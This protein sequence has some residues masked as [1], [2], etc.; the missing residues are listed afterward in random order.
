[1]VMLAL[2]KGVN[3]VACKSRSKPFSFCRVRPEDSNGYFTLRAL[4]LVVF[5]P[6][7]LG[8]VHPQGDVANPIAVAIG[9]AQRSHCPVAKEW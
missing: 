3:R 1:M 5:S 4:P 2:D 8:V 7:S 6:C 9:C